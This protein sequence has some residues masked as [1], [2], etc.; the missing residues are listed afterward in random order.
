MSH[1]R[2]D[3]RCYCF[4]VLMFLLAFTPLQT[5]MAGEHIFNQ[6]S[7]FFHSVGRIAGVVL[8]CA[9]FA[10]AVQGAKRKKRLTYGI[11]KLRLYVC[12]LSYHDVSLNARVVQD[13]LFE[14]KRRKIFPL[15]YSFSVFL[16]FLSLA[17]TVCFGGFGS[18][19]KLW[20]N[21]EKFGNEF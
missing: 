14:P 3:F 11:I 2:Q 15:I 8:C 1:I 6:I 4:L 10:E 13:S 18:W 9:P 12:T 16:F 5:G 19:W 21:W 17:T 7:L 20:Y